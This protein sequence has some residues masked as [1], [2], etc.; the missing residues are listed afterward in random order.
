MQSKSAARPGEK[1]QQHRRISMGRKKEVDVG[2]TFSN[3][4]V[5]LGSPPVEERADHH[6]G[7]RKTLFLGERKRRMG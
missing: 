5:T 6:A 3:P 7:F 2:R 4:R 1:K